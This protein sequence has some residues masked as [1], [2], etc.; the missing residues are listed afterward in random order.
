MPEQ[1]QKERQL[2]EILKRRIVEQ[3]QAPSPEEWQQRNFETLS[4]QIEEKT[5]VLLSISTLKR[6]WKNKYQKL[7]HKNTLNAL[8][9]FIGFKDWY[10]FVCNN[11]QKV[12]TPKKKKEIIIH[13]GSSYLVISASVIA[14]ILLVVLIFKTQSATNFN[15]ALFSSET[16][17]ESG[18]PNTV[19]FDY[20]I[21][22]CEFDSAFIQQSWDFRRRSRI[23]KNENQST[24]VYYFPGYH[25]AK[26]I[27]NDQIVK[28]HIVYI[29]TDNW[30][31]LVQN[32]KNERIP[33]YL[34]ENCISQGEIQVTPQQLADKNIDL[35]TNDYRVSYIFMNEKIWCDTDNF[36]FEAKVRNSLDEGGITCQNCQIIFHGTSGM[37]MLNFCDT[38]C[39][40][41][42]SQLFSENYSDGRKND[43]S[44]FGTD[45]NDWKKISLAIKNKFATVCLEGDDIFS[46]TYENGIGKLTGITISFLGCGAIDYVALKNADNETFY[47]EDFN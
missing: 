32:A 12:D 13:G 35:E 5:N 18:V 31:T 44:A 38:G 24:S 36:S 28:E 37:H 26:L 42:I 16:T 19:V 3:L 46:A 29:K 22:K 25:H 4:N 14:S 11:Q 1:I 2:I 41:N 39:I 23:N 47:E 20:D 34:R 8:A 40:G 7:P 33:V 6:I 9:L 27:L 15:E 45:F 21:S 30:L 43:L 10:D 17:V